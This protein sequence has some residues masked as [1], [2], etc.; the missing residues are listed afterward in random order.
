[1][2]RR[3]KRES[4]EAQKEVS[5]RRKWISTLIRGRSRIT[6][7]L[8]IKSSTRS[9]QTSSRDSSLNSWI[10]MP[11]SSS[12]S[13]SSTLQIPLG[14]T[15][16]IRCQTEGTHSNSTPIRWRS[17]S[18]QMATITIGKDPNSL[19]NKLIIRTSK[20]RR[21][22][23]KRTNSSTT[24]CKIDPSLTLTKLLSTKVRWMVATSQF[25]STKAKLCNRTSSY[26]SLFR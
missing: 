18:T 21:S 5:T 12:S 19:T 6:W 15:L 24:S 10:D 11:S 16:R 26:I 13:S 17:N 4:K 8:A 25:P 2:S 14:K 9:T 3:S 1:M 7:T 22:I 23:R 20:S